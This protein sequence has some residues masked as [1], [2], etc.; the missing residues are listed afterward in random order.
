[1]KKLVLVAITAIM[2]LCGSM[3]M[4]QPP[5]GQGGQGGRGQQMTTEERVAM[6][7]EQLNLTDKQCEQITALE[8]ERQENQTR[9]QEGGERP[10]R[11]AMQKAMQEAQEAQLTEMKKILTEEQFTKYQEMMQQ[12]QQRQRSQGGER[13]TRQ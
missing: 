4:A 2:T 5:Q 9:P 13:P 3:A 11:E 7:K 12:Q 1:M 6:L 8:T 10:D